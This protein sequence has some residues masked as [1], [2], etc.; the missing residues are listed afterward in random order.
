MPLDKEGYPEYNFHGGC[1]YC[2]QQDIHGVE[3]CM[4]C[5]YFDANWNLPNLSNRPATKAEEMRRFLKTMAS[6]HIKG[7]SNV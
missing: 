7:I 2:T 5:Q 3:F 6:S 4:G 1:H